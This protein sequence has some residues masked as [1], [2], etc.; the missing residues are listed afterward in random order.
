MNDFYIFIKVRESGG[1]L[2]HVYMYWTH[3]Q[4]LL[5]SR[6]MDFHETWYGQSTQ[7]PLHVWKHFGQILPGGGT[8]A[9]PKKVTGGPLLHQTGWLQQQTECIAM[10]YKLVV[11]S[12]VISGSIPKSKFWCVFDV[13]LDLVILPY[14]TC[15]NVIS[16]DHY[17]VKCWINVYFVE[18][19]FAS[20]EKL[21]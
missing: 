16:I 15:C 3:S 18:L 1:Q 13:F 5:Q 17:A 4:T 9:G 11:R 8:R 6:W 20:W 10:I 12:V 14:C 7:G 21:I 19:L 2:M